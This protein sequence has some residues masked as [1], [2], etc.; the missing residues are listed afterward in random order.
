ML[1]NSKQRSHNFKNIYD[2]RNFKQG[3]SNEILFTPIMK[4]TYCNKN[5][6]ELVQ[7]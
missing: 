2:K 6:I 5:V 1:T 4:V 3:S 7:A